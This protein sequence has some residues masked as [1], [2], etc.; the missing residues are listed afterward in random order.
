MDRALT[1]TVLDCQTGKESRME[2]GRKSGQMGASDCIRGEEG[3]AVWYVEGGRVQ[4]GRSQE[5][6]ASRR[7]IKGKGER[8]FAPSS[9]GSRAGRLLVCQSVIKCPLVV[10]S[11]RHHELNNTHGP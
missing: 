1:V 10:K 5:G 4:T 8:G 11:L 6:V 9:H 2:W 3:E 7:E